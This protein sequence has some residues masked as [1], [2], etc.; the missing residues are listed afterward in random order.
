MNPILQVDF[1]APAPAKKETRWQHQGGGDYVDRRTGNHYE[2]VRLNGR[3]TW[4]KLNATTHAAA[5]KEIRKKRSDH[6]LSKFGIA[7]DPYKRNAAG[8][9]AVLLDDYA[10]AGFP[11]TRN[12]SIQRSERE[13]KDL[14][15]H[16]VCLKKFLGSRDP[17]KITHEDLAAYHAWRIKQIDNPSRPGHRSVDKERSTLS[18]AYDFAIKRTSQSGITANPFARNATRFCDPGS[19]QH[20]RDFQPDNAEELHRIGD[21]LAESTRSEATMFQ[22]FYEAMIGQRSAEILR[23]RTDAKNQNEPGF[24]T[25][26]CLFLYR[27]KT[28]KGTYPYADINPALRS[29]I[30]AHKNWLRIRYP[31]GTP[32]YFPSPLNPK[33]P[34]TPGA[35]TK[36]LERVTAELRLPRRKSHG[37][38]SYCMN[39]YRTDRRADGTHRYTDNEIAIRHGQKTQGKLLVDVYGEIPPYRLTWLPEG[40][41]PSWARWLPAAGI[42]AEQLILGI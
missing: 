4:R 39:V 23:L 5:L 12:R 1:T 6:E 36:A 37:L 13:L 9:V 32:W 21:V 28:N 7:E 29:L 14:R 2:N 3:Y 24:V 18:L 27:S 40:R 15:R 17:K 26:N 31:N 42:R 20:C 41:Q 34:L 10:A 30:E 8:T 33:E 38:R 25:K 16:I 35:L 22:M 19:V 11:K